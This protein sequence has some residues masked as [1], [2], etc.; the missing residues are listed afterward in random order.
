[1][2]EEELR[3]TVAKNIVI[4]RKQQGLTQT[5]LAER[6]H[7]TDKSVSKWERAEGLPDV[8][9]LTQ[10]AELF[11]VSVGDLLSE[12]PPPSRRGPR[13]VLV[14]VLS[15]G[16]AWLAASVVFLGLC[17]FAP[18]LPRPWLSFCYGLAVSFIILIV[19][20]SLW[21]GLRESCLAVSG[22]IW[23]L[24]LCVHLTANVPGIGFIWIVAAV[25]QVLAA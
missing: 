25:M 21:W 1:M 22:L 4:L 2:T 14:T 3:R 11:G 13:R 15:V 24:A 5:E 17:V 19:F 10:L 18:E 8:F 6:L 16:L 12:T 23:S 7:Y 20:T 9:V